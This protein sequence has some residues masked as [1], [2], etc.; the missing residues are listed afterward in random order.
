MKSLFSLLLTI[1]L[2]VVATN[3]QAQRHAPKE[4]YWV[5]ES[6]IKTPQKC[7]VYFYNNQHQLVYKEETNDLKLDI[8][9]GK[10]RRQLN[11]VLQQSIAAHKRESGQLLA[12]RFQ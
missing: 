6:N 9:K 8:S 1:L 12:S 5:V 4:G 2:L 10:V 7:T 3:T 11:A